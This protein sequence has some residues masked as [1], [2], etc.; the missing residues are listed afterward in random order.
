L[1][2]SF[3]VLNLAAANH[4]RE[5]CQ[6][7]GTPKEREQAIALIAAYREQHEIS[8]THDIDA[9]AREL[10][11]LARMSKNAHGGIPG[12]MLRRRMSAADPE[13]YNE[14]QTKLAQLREEAMSL[15][16]PVLRRVLVS[17]VSRL[18]NLPWRQRPDS[19]LMA[20][21]FAMGMNGCCTRTLF[22]ALCF[23]VE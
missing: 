3:A 2:V 9:T 22:A 11:Q 13:K 8:A 4:A 17:I 5:R 7:V 18:L 21:Q 10:D 14:A 19:K 16:T 15:V 20:C 23:L 6:G 1:A 12:E